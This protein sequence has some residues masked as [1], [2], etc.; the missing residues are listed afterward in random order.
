MSPASPPPPESKVIFV[1]IFSLLDA[2]QVAQTGDATPDAFDC[3]RGVVV[4]DEDLLQALAATV[5]MDPPFD[6]AASLSCNAAIYGPPGGGSL[7]GS[8]ASFTGS[9]TVAGSEI[10]REISVIGLI[11]GH[12]FG[13]VVLL[14][15]IIDPQ[16]DDLYRDIYVGWVNED[17][18]YH[19]TPTRFEVQSLCPH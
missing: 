16:T 7:I 9:C 3:V 5:E 18:I 10:S 11:V 12:E 1:S 2:H 15:G 14:S 4:A 19:F 13:R 17:D 8:L 6:V